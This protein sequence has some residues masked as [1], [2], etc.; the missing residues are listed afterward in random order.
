VGPI[1]IHVAG[2]PERFDEVVESRSLVAA[3]GRNNEVDIVLARRGRIRFV[4]QDVTAPD[5][6]GDD[7]PEGDVT[8]G[9]VRAGRFF[10]QSDE[11]EYWGSPPFGH[12]VES[13][14]MVPVGRHEVRF[15]FEGYQPVTRAF[16]VTEHAA[17]VVTIWLQPR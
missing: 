15:E 5:R 11:M 1:A 13:M 2:Y 14:A 9:S 8:I 3:A 12:P 7:G 16:D 4:L 6:R 17:E 10:W